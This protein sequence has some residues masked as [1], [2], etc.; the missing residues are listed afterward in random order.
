MDTSLK[1]TLIVGATEKEGRYANL[2]AYRLLRHGHEIALVGLKEGQIEGRP[3]Q[4][5]QPALENIDTVT[6]YVG[7]RNQ[8]PLYD[9]IKSLKP[10]RVIF[11]PGAENPEFERQLKAE[12]IEPIEA[13]T[14]VMLSVGTY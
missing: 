7:P 14:L 3:I 6:M 5:G 10:R 12:G 2:A 1:K 11:N 9:Y 8:P 4:V 13:C